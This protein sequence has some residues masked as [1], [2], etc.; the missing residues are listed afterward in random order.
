M[1]CVFLLIAVLVASPITVEVMYLTMAV[2]IWALLMFH[3]NL[4]MLGIISPKRDLFVTRYLRPGQTELRMQFCKML[5]SYNSLTDCPIID[6][7]WG[8]RQFSI[9]IAHS[10]LSEY[11]YK[12]QN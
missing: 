2:D 6:W 12:M 9:H 7:C 5:Y 1:G 3:F 4:F 11:S 10:K 8:K